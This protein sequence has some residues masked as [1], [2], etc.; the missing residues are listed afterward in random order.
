MLASQLD[1]ISTRIDEI[2]AQITAWH[3]ANPVSQ[4]LAAIPGIGPLIA[5][6]IAATV[7]DPAAFRS[8]REF[9]AWVGLTPR[10]KSTAANSVWDASAGKVTNTSDGC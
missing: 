2:D 1:A 8:A 6:A 9:A 7:A 3:K 10:Q 5:T 4:R